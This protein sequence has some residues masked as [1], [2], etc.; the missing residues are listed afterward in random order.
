MSKM[1]L[2][3]DFGFVFFDDI[4]DWVGNNL[5]PSDVFDEKELNEWATDNNF[6]EDIYDEDY[7]IDWAETNGYIKETEA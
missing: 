7:L 6:V 5:D 1:Q 2:E 4:V 3:R